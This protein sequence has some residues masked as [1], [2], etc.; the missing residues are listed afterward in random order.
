MEEN[1]G[2]YTWLNLSDL[3]WPIKILLFAVAIFII[4]LPYILITRSNP[5]NEAVRTYD[6]MCAAKTSGDITKF[7]GLIDQDFPEFK[8]TKLNQLFKSFT[9]FNRKHSKIQFKRDDDGYYWIR[10]IHKGKKEDIR[11]KRKNHTMFI[12]PLGKFYVEPYTPPKKK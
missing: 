8:K 4:A 1:Q 3:P 5:Y 9:C 12:A 10:V 7:S 2:S 6:H 11:F